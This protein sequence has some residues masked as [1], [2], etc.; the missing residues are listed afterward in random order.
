[1]KAGLITLSNNPNYELNILLI[2]VQGNDVVARIPPDQTGFINALQNLVQRQRQ[3]QQQQRA[4][5]LFSC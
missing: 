2:V 3:Q 5:F 1:M 4:V